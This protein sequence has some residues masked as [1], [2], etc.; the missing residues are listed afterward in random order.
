MSPAPVKRRDRLSGKALRR[1]IAS[2]MS[3]DNAAGPDLVVP[4]L[5][6]YLAISG[7]AVRRPNRPQIS[8]SLAEYDRGHRR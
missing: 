3:A 1:E 8:R 7:A 4:R 6:S 5:D 2:E